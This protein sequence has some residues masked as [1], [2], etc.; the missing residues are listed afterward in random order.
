MSFDAYDYYEFLK[1]QRKGILVQ[2]QPHE[3]KKLAELGFTFS[4]PDKFTGACSAY[5]PDNWSLEYPSYSPIGR[6]HVLDEKGR[7]RVVSDYNDIVREPTVRL[8]CRYMYYRKFIDKEYKIEEIYFGNEKE[9]IF[10]AGQ[11]VHKSNM[12]REEAIE[13][14]ER[15]KALAVA[16]EKFAQ[17]NYPDYLDPAAYWDSEV[18]ADDQE[19]KR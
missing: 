1:R 10:V 13:Y 19:P 11:L 18:L 5:L 15:E 4:E 17:E 14:F 12:S 3:K 16:V 2:N 9:K 7:L 6:G 8:L